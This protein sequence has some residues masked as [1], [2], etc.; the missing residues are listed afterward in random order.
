[1]VIGKFVDIISFHSGEFVP[2]TNN[3][4]VLIDE[5]LKA[6]SLYFILR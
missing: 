3:S 5:V 6:D 1:M 4:C 2:V